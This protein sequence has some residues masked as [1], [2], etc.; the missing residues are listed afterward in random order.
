MC[1]STPPKPPPPWGGVP[2]CLRGNP[3]GV[4]ETGWGGRPL[5]DVEDAMGR[6]RSAGHLHGQLRVRYPARAS[7]RSRPDSD[8]DPGTGKGAAGAADAVGHLGIR[9]RVA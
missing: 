3:P 1:P 4:R 7:E 8:A 2:K 6:A 5:Y 9:T